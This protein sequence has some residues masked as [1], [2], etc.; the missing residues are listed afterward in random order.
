MV[1]AVLEFFLR[2]PK[3]KVLVYFVLFIL[4]LTYSS[5]STVILGKPLTETIPETVL[6]TAVLFA[7]A[8]TI[9]G[10]MLAKPK[11]SR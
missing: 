10:A 3:L 8:I 2:R 5:I 6:L 9:V 11:R 4:G 1:E 7:T